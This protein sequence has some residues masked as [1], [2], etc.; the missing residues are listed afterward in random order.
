M[1]GAGLAL[2]SQH[3]GPIDPPPRAPQCPFS[4]LSL[5][6]AT[7]CPLSTLE[8]TWKF[9]QPCLLPSVEPGLTQVPDESPTP[10]GS[11][12]ALPTFRGMASLRHPGTSLSSTSP[13]Q[14]LGQMSS[15][16]LGSR[17]L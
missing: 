7:S 9:C 3:G 13:P 4:G 10:K 16:L 11:I 8:L 14:S 1:G 5:T 15:D 2:V 12:P 6:M 17:R